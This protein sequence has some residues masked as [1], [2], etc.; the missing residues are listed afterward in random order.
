MTNTNILMSAARAADAMALA[1]SPAAVAEAALSVAAELGYH[2]MS[3]V[4]KPKDGPQTDA[5]ILYSNIRWEQVAKY[6][7]RTYAAIDPVVQRTLRGRAPRLLSGIGEERLSPVERKIF[8]SYH[9][10]SGIQ[11]GLVIPVRRSV[12]PDGVITFGGVAPDVSA[13]AQSAL[14]L[15][16]H[17]AYGR[18]EQLRAAR[19][20]AAQP[21]SPVLTR[22]EIEVLTWVSK[23]KSDGETSTILGMSERTA[24]FHVANAKTKLG[25][26]TRVQAVTMAMER[27]LIES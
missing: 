8:A 10:A 1:P 13:I 15:L 25:A 27:G 19:D 5:S 26:S 7:A 20:P 4:E 11:D 21:G 22:R 16:G 12:H 2:S 23:G 3:I 17:C 18:M 9:C 14:T 6:R 24:R